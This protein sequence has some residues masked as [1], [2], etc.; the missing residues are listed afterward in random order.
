VRVAVVLALLL[1]APGP[2]A[3]SVASDMLSTTVR[4]VCLNPGGGP[5][6]LEVGSGF[7]VGCGD[8]V[9][10]NW[11][12]VE[13]TGHGGRAGVLLGHEEAVHSAL[14]QAV[15]QPWRTE[16]HGY[17][18]IV[19]DAPAHA[20]DGAYALAAGFASGSERGRVSVS[21]VRFLKLSTIVVDK[22]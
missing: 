5:D 9:V 20:A 12:V 2:L 3:A 13:C 19:G 15:A 6:R 8:H 16:P 11:H 7:V 4:V 22:S 18:I 14:E 1:A 10:T 17:I 21:A